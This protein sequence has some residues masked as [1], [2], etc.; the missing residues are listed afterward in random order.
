MK[1]PSDAAQRAVEL[2]KREAK[3]ALLELGGGQ[4][5]DTFFFVDF[6][7]RA[8]VSAKA[9]ATGRQAARRGQRARGESQS[10]GSLCEVRT[11]TTLLCVDRAARQSVFSV[12]RWPALQP[13]GPRPI[14]H[15]CD[16]LSCTHHNPRPASTPRPDHLEIG[17]SHRRRNAEDLTESTRRYQP[18]PA[19]A[20]PVS[21]L[22]S[23]ATFDAYQP[24]RR[25]YTGQRPI[26]R[27]S[28]ISAILR[29]GVNLRPLTA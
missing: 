21:P 5:R 17:P 1:A 4:G 9:G 13:S 19:A 24:L 3:T 8:T 22:R 16:S 26:S 23:E 12:L 25:L 15:G 28:K 7:D 6:F 20:T 2:L 10:F 18:K 11:G 14:R 27:R 29:S